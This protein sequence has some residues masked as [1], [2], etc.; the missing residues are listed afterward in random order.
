MLNFVNFDFDN[1]SILS[2][3]FSSHDSHDSIIYAL[4]LSTKIWLSL[5]LIQI[6]IFLSSLAKADNSKYVYIKFVPFI[7]SFV[8]IFKFNLFQN[9]NLNFKLCNF[10]LFWNLKTSEKFISKSKQQPVTN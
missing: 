5:R 9:Y 3:G 4:I 6:Q 10:F 8:Y 1:S 7:L 2:S